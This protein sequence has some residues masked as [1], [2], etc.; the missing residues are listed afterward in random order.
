MKDINKSKSVLLKKDKYNT[1]KINN[2][3]YVILIFGSLFLLTFKMAITYF[4]KYYNSF[5]IP[6]IIDDNGINKLINL[7]EKTHYKRKNSP[8]NL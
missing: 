7:H 5:N 1:K 4:I 2:S 6:I 8:L 3:K